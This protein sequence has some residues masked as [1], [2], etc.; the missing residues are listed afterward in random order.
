METKPRPSSDVE[1]ALALIRQLV[2]QCPRRLPTTASEKKAQEIVADKLVRLGLEI[3]WQ[4]FAFSR[5]LY[6]N[7]A[8]HFLLGALGTAVAALSAWAGLFLHL[9][10][11]VSYLADGERFYLL[12]RVL[13]F[14]PSQNLIAVAPAKKQPQR[15]LVLIGHADAAFTGYI[16]RPELAR[17]VARRP[18]PG[19]LG[20]PLALAVL[21]LLAL[22]GIDLLQLIAVN[23]SWKFWLLAAGLT[24]LPLIAGLFSLEVVLRDEA[25]PGAND[26]LSGAA[27]L[28]ALAGR[29]VPAKP[30]DLELVF[31]LAG[32]EEASMGGSDAL[33]R[34]ASREWDPRRTAVLAIDTIGRGELRYLEFEGELIK[35]YVPG[36]LAGVLESS[37]S[38]DPRFAGLRPMQ[39]PVGGTDAQP[40]LVR[41]F[42]AAGITCIEPELGTSLHYHL[43]DDRPEYLIPEQLARSLDFVESVCRALFSAERWPRG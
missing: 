28:P 35:R 36:W 19:I 1:E 13:G 3:R 42:P 15:R 34:V 33:A 9:I 40:F 41:G 29:L 39:P 5:S 12:R 31:V 22:A 23:L 32:C 6:A 18:L 30:D 4:P 11:A 20:R 43:P 27:A 7:L 17:R 2:E 26:N 14:A 10:A 38:S 37:A 21:A 25:V 8:L 16:F 24:V